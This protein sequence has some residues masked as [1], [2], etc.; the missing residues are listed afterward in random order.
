[1]CENDT[2]F[3]TMPTKEEIEECK[4][5]NNAYVQCDTCVPGN[6]NFEEKHAD[7]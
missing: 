6:R 7:S 4:I 5:C 3:R 2:F 1:M